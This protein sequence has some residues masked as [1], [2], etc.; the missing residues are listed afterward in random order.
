[1]RLR[2]AIELGRSEID[3]GQ[4]AREDRCELGQWLCDGIPTG[5]R[6]SP[7]YTKVRAV[8]ADLHREVGRILTLALDGESG[9]A[10]ALLVPGSPFQQLSNALVSA[11]VAWQAES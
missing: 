2:H 4:A 8:H 1:M 5:D 7:H 6:R 9:D 11:L 3:P 10:R